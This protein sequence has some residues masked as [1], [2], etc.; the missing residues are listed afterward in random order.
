MYRVL[1]GRE[2]HFKG[3]H[4]LGGY[5]CEVAVEYDPNVLKVISWRYLSDP[6]LCRFKMLDP[7]R[8]RI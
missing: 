5:D 3:G 4:Y 2:I 6:K 1:P 8:F 7:W